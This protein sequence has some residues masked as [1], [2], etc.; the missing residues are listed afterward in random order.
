MSWIRKFSGAAI[1]FV[2]M[3]LLCCGGLLFLLISSGY[4]LIL[5]QEGTN[6]IFLIPFLLRSSSL[7][8]MHTET[9]L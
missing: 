5:R 4:L 2:L 7:W 3:H 8:N 1:P 9:G 6:K